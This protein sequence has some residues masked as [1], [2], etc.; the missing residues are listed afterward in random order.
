MNLKFISEDSLYYIMKCSVVIVMTLNYSLIVD[1]TI[2]MQKMINNNVKI[3]E[4]LFNIKNFLMF[5][6][7]LTDQHDLLKK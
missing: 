2:L 3:K 1:A 6:M 5:C 4:N 7:L